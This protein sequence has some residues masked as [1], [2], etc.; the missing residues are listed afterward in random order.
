MDRKTYLG[1]GKDGRPGASPSYSKC[2]P[3]KGFLLRNQERVMLAASHAVCGQM[4]HKSGFLGRIY[5]H[6]KKMPHGR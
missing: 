6:G 1:S 4:T 5:L 2:D 3:G